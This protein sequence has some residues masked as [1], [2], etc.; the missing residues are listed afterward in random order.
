[1]GFG[2]VRFVE[3]DFVG[4]GSVRGTEDVGWEGG[5]VEGD[6]PAGMDWH[7][8]ELLYNERNVGKLGRRK[9]YRAYLRLRVKNGMN[10]ERRSWLG[11]WI[12]TF[13]AGR[14]QVLPKEGIFA[15][16]ESTYEDT[17]LEIE[18]SGSAE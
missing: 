6:F 17:L 9:V 10:K 18:M 7:I 13:Q 8:E 2:A 12:G 14:S 15:R 11:T 4:E 16:V 1:M 5:V 3:G